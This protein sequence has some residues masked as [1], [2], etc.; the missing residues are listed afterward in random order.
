M[1]KA[2]CAGGHSFERR[3]L[4]VRVE[5]SGSRIAAKRRNNMLEGQ[6]KR[7]VMIEGWTCENASAFERRGLRDQRGGDCAA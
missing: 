3:T 2:P 7:L 5:D 4:T 1:H 6:D